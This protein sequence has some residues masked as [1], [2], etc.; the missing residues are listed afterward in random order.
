MQK[1]DFHH[2]H[3]RNSDEFTG[4]S[5]LAPMLITQTFLQDIYKQCECNGV[6]KTRCTVSFLKKI[7]H[8]VM[9]LDSSNSAAMTTGWPPFLPFIPHLPHKHAPKASRTCGTNE[10]LKKWQ[11]NELTVGCCLFH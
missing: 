7:A 9:N 5:S 6:R 2:E 11:V 4:F 8:T 1:I 3:H 10:V